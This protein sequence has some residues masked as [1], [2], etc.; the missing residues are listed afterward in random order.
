MIDCVTTHPQH[1]TDVELR[2][3]VVHS[4]VFITERGAGARLPDRS[5]R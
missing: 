4:P 3:I 1:G 5:L 2:G